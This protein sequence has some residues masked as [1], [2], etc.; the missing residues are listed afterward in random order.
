MIVVG[1]PDLG[2][3]IRDL[4]AEFGIEFDEPGTKVMS[5]YEY[6]YEDDMEQQEG[7]H[8]SFSCTGLK[9]SEIHKRNVYLLQRCRGGFMSS[10]V[11]VILYRATF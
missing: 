5:H 7:Q 9:I 6:M 10:L 8:A 4:G 1:S 11:K 3:A 2:D